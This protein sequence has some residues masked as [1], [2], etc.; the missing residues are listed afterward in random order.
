MEELT[1]EERSAALRT[2]NACLELADLCDEIVAIAPD[3]SP[4]DFLTALGALAAGIDPGIRGI[5]NLA[6]G[7]RNEIIGAGFQ[8]EFDDD[9]A[10]QARHFAGTAA[11]ATRFGSTPTE[12][13]AH[14]LLDPPDTADGRLSTAAIEFARALL[15]GQLEP[16]QTGDWVRRR[17]CLEEPS[18]TPVSDG[19][20]AFEVL[21]RDEPEAA[22]VRARFSVDEWASLIELPESVIVAASLSERDSSA[23]QLREVVAGVQLLESLDGRAGTPLVTAVLA[24]RTTRFEIVERLTAL[25]DASA[26]IDTVLSEVERIMSLLEER[27][28]SVEDRSGYREMIREA[29]RSAAEA[30]SLGGILGLG[31]Q[32]VSA[33]E[34]VFLDRLDERLRPTAP[35]DQ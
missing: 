25:D 19:P 11:S 5:Y 26:L 6:R 34:R 33:N 27:D 4:K 12:L 2:N 1:P 18:V 3:V 16:S 31:G 8:P 15:G 29:A 9:S 13:V 20:T 21:T 14:K 30:V 10:G 35:H 32:A 7:G 28:I 23:D 17:L 22:E 24:A